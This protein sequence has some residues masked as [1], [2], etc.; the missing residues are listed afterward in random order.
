MKFL[1]SLY[2]SSP[3]L[4]NGDNYNFQSLGGCEDPF[5]SSYQV[6]YDQLYMN[7]MILR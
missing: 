1:E 2:T 6:L 4:Y 5:S 3:D 7:T